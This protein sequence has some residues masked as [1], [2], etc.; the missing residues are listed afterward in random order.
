MPKVDVQHEVES[1]GTFRVTGETGFA[2]E[3]FKFEN[4]ELGTAE[5]APT[6]QASF[7]VTVTGA[8]PALAGMLIGIVQNV[9]DQRETI[10]CMVKGKKA[11]AKFEYPGRQHLD[12]RADET[13]VAPYYSKK[14]VV[15]LPEL[16]GDAAVT[17]TVTVELGDETWRLTTAKVTGSTTYAIWLLAE[18]A[19]ASVILHSSSWHVDWTNQK[20]SEPADA[21]AEPVTEVPIAAQL[22]PTA[23]LVAK[24][25]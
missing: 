22:P 4:T 16:A 21:P 3:E 5:R 23:M 9:T 25:T 7:T 12:L 8:A 11:L 14:S 10:P 6:F 1:V 2:G 24:P 20:V 15:T 18:T 13:S 19:D 17:K